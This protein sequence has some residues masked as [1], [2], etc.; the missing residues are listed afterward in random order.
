MVD[1]KHEALRERHWREIIQQTNIHLQSDDQILTLENIFQM[2]LHQYH[3]TIQGNRTIDQS[4]PY[5]PL[6]SSS[7]LFCRPRSENYRSRN[8]SKT[9]NSNGRRC[10]FKSTNINVIHRPPLAHKSVD[11]S[12]RVLMR[13]FN[14][15]KIPLYFYT[16]SDHADIS[17]S[18][19]LSRCLGMTTSR[20]VGVY[21]SQVEQWI[22]T[23]SLIADVIKLWTIV[24]QKW[25]YLENIFLGSTLQFGEEAKRFDTADKLFRKIMLGKVLARD[26]SFFVYERPIF[27]NITQSIGEG[28]M[29]AFWSLR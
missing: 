9:F 22:R 14:C 16:V 29:L 28:V 12:S 3:E 7:Q 8:I 21:L 26:F 18:L 11:L 25:M 5:C 20:F 4:S 19:F 1:L 27:R 23:L 13:F 6:F 2:N 24:Q 17:L 15:W 10:D